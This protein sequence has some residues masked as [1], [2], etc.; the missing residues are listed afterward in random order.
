[1]SSL[2]PSFRRS[3]VVSQL[4]CP[5]CRKAP[6]D[7][8]EDF[9]AGDLICLGCGT[10]LERVIDM[11][12]EWRTFANESSGIADDPS[13]VGGPSNP[14]LDTDSLETAISHRDGMTGMSK[15]LSRLQNKA[16]FRPE[17]KN[18]LPNFR[19]IQIFCE[20]ASLTRGVSDRAKQLFK[21]ADEARLT[22]SGRFNEAIVAACLMEA[23]RLERVSRTF[24]EISS[25]CKV[26][27]KDLG[28]AHR[29]LKAALLPTEEEGGPQQ[30]FTSLETPPPK[31]TTSAAV[32][33]PISFEYDTMVARYCSLLRIPP[34]LHLTIVAVTRR[35]FESGLASGKSP[36]SIACASI[37]LMAQLLPRQMIGAKVS[38]RDIAAVSG[39]AENTIRINY[40]ELYCSR[41]KLVPEGAVLKEVLDALPEPI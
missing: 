8:T 1:M 18:L 3:E 22:R 24:K 34:D 19:T 37:Y 12:S 40:R 23:C 10:V 38:A 31:N 2:G 16:N 33:E 11:T 35:A 32:T 9:A 15:E 5:T 6:P 29:D 14:L 27:K 20:Q 17:D 13:R 28:R 7:T 21:K 39:I 41:H 30:P 4:Y 25:L 36:I 26:S